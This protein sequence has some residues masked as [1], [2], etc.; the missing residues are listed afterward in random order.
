MN[1]RKS[2][3]CWNKFLTFVHISFSPPKNFLLY[4]SKLK[5][6]FVLYIIVSLTRVKNIYI[7]HLTLS[8]RALNWIEANFTNFWFWRFSCIQR[9]YCTVCEK[10]KK[11]GQWFNVFFSLLYIEQLNINALRKKIMIFYEFLK[12]L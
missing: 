5:S 2:S 6:K 4:P 11:K 3:N 7:R 1:E 10:S 9:Y 12:K 8:S